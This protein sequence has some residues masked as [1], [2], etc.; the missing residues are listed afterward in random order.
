MSSALPRTR[1]P[2]YPDLDSCLRHN[3][4]IFSW[5][6]GNR[7]HVRACLKT[8]NLRTI[9]HEY[10]I[11]STGCIWGLY[12][13]AD[14]ARERQILEAIKEEVCSRPDRATTLTLI[15]LGNYGCGGGGAHDGK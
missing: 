3:G 15:Q 10:H 6:D 2:R 8:L 1:E 9:H 5:S 13:P 7:K 14:A 11:R 12:S 4:L